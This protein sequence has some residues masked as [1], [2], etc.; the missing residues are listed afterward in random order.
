M[1]AVR[2][3]HSRFMGKRL[4][5]KPKPG[6]RRRQP[7]KK[8]RRTFRTDGTF[9]VYILECADGSYYTGYTND[10]VARLKL[11]NSGRGAKYVRS[12][13]PARLVFHKKF[14]DYR[15]A[16]AE[17]RRIK[18]LSRPD[19]V[20]LV[21]RKRPKQIFSLKPSKRPTRKAVSSC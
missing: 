5:R 11:H 2:I 18:K 9:F 8:I 17:E 16:M 1:S 3:I 10:L 14:M 19:K 7:R 6:S 13:C 12:R 20:K 4:S 15:L 21:S